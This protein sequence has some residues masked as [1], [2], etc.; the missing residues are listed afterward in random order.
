MAATCQLCCVLDDFQ[1]LIEPLGGNRD[2]GA[3][4]LREEG[5]LE[6]FDHP[7]KGFDLT[8]RFG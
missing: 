7:P 1:L 2:G 6:L 3:Y 5:D 8:L 4:L